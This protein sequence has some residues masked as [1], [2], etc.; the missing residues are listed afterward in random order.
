MQYAFLAFV[1]AVPKQQYKWLPTVAIG[2]ILFIL[3]SRLIN[4]EHH[5][6]NEVVSAGIEPGK[7]YYRV[8]QE[9]TALKRLLRQNY[10]F[11]GIR[12]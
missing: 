9:T 2:L 8:D 4:V 1:T 5:L 12:L 3:P 10:I 6:I 11:I 7:S